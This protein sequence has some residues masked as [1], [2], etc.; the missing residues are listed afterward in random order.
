MKILSILLSLGE[1][2]F[3]AWAERSPTVRIRA[4]LII[5]GNLLVTLGFLYFGWN[6]AFIFFI[7]F[8]ETAAMFVFQ[9]LK[10]ICVHGKRIS[11]KGKE[12]LVSKIILAIFEIVWSA[13]FYGIQVAGKFMVL[14]L[15]TE[16]ATGGMTFVKGADN[17][18]KLQ[19]S[20]SHA[21]PTAYWAH[22]Q[23]LF[24][25]NLQNDSGTQSMADHL[26]SEWFAMIIVLLT[27]A[28]RYIQEIRVAFRQTKIPEVSEQMSRRLM[29][30]GFILIP[31]ALLI[32]TASHDTSKLYSLI[33]FLIAKTI[34]DLRAIPV[35]TPNGES[36]DQV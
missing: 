23:Q 13:G 25:Q 16:I 15:I 28:I 33:F 11:T 19:E 24:F 20:V 18:L 22:L 32:G 27:L 2:A 3:P 17:S 26:D 36:T 10:I 30:F 5:A 34:I 14:I 29:W 8:F 21:D 35:Y 7:F 4:S 12:S 6:L 1:F 9:M 31:Q